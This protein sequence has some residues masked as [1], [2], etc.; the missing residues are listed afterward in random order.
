M[1][2]D[3][4]SHWNIKYIIVTAN[5]ANVIMPRRHT[6]N[7]V[8][9]DLHSTTVYFRVF[10]NFSSNGK[11]GWNIFGELVKRVEGL[12]NTLEIS[13][14]Y[15]N[16]SVKSASNRFDRFLCPPFPYFYCL[17]DNFFHIFKSSNFR[18]CNAH[19]SLPGTKIT[20][21]SQLRTPVTVPKE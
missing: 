14:R 16:C 2:N 17:I 10:L 4:E 21:K 9:N 8:I 15:V 5:F 1:E 3:V 13:T 7:G 11:F 18:G 6:Q 12:V 20:Q 19:I